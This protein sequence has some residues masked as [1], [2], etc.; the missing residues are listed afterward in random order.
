VNALPLLERGLARA[1]AQC[2]LRFS[3]TTGDRKVAE[4]IITSAIAMHRCVGWARPASGLPLAREGLVRAGPS[5]DTAVDVH[6]D[7]FNR[8]A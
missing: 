2:E 6:H 4:S 3:A 5:H 7:Q 1:V 8:I